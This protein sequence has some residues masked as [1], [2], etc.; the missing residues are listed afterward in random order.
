MIH[1][2]FVLGR[3][4]EIRLRA[5]TAGANFAADKGRYGGRFGAVAGQ[6]W[7]GYD[8]KAHEERDGGGNN[9]DCFS[10]PRSLGR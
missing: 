1:R 9:K 10:G 5:M 8:T 6:E 2:L 7:P 3:T 4:P